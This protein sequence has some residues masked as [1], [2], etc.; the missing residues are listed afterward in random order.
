MTILKNF[1]IEALRR[2]K[3]RKAASG[4]VS[5]VDAINEISPDIAKL[6]VG[7][8]AAVAVPKGIKLRVAVMNIVAKL[9]NL[10]PKGGEWEGRDYAVVSDGEATVYVQRGEDLKEPVERKRRGPGSKA[11]TKAEE[12]P[13]ATET[14]STGTSTTSTAK[15]G[16]VVKENA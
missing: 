16:A 15:S 1:D 11:E 7:E 5:L 14:A 2:Q 8:T 12:A 6:K 3:A 4:G 10:T 9:N 13:K